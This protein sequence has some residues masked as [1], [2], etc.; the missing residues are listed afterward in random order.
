MDKEF[1]V[2]DRRRLAELL[3]VHPATLYQA[4]TGK[5]AGFSPAKCVQIERDSRGELRRWHL[6]PN[7]W[8]LIWPEIIDADGAPKAPAQPEPNGA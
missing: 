8:W 6:R 5:G 1:T 7:D 2:E 4:L 3:K